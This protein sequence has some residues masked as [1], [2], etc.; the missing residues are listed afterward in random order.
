MALSGTQHAPQS[1]I[2]LLCVCDV[3]NIEP[4]RIGSDAE[5]T[6][7]PIHTNAQLHGKR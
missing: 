4:H 2:L 1:G 6:N 7:S 5:Q 3:R